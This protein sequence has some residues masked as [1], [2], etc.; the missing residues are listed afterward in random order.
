MEFMCTT[1]TNV[2]VELLQRDDVLANKSRSPDLHVH[3]APN[4]S[5]AKTKLEVRLIKGG[6]MKLTIK[7]I[8]LEDGGD[9][10]CSLPHPG[11]SAVMTL[12]VVSNYYCAKII[13]FVITVLFVLTLLL[14]VLIFQFKSCCKSESDIE[15]TYDSLKMEIPQFVDLIETITDNVP[16]GTVDITSDQPPKYEPKKEEPLQDKP[17]NYEPPKCKPPKYKP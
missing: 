17:P 10:L 11:V 2:Y 3:L 14:T 15:D 13:G 5:T 16:L 1:N 6:S 12:K 7:D 9:Y 8:A 4:V